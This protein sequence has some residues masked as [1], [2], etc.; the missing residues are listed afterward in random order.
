MTTEQQK[1]A[2]LE[3]D[4]QWEREGKAELYEE[5]KSQR[6]RL[7]EITDEHAALEKAFSAL[8]QEKDA[9]EQKCE[10]LRATL[11]RER[12]E[13]AQGESV[14]YLQWKETDVKGTVMLLVSGCAAGAKNVVIPET[15]EGKRVLGVEEG[16]FAGCET[17]ET[18]DLPYGVRAVAEH[19]FSNCPNLKLARIPKSVVWMGEFSFEGS[20]NA[21][22]A[23]APGSY[24]HWFAEFHGHEILPP[25]EHEVV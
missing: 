24:A 10:L 2:Q 8:Q 6:E 17:L 21:A 7:A 20:Q 18:V 25:E 5:F 15:F 22:I 12:R 13:R 23:C 1:I 9:L 19:A 3:S 11:V 14:R 16:A 4:L